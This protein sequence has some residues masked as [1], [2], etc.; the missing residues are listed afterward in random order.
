MRTRQKGSMLLALLAAGGLGGFGGWLFAA[1][2]MPATGAPQ[3][4]IQGHIQNGRLIRTEEPILPDPGAQRA[5]M[6]AALRDIEKQLVAI[7]RHARM[8]Y[9]LLG[10]QRD[11][12][13][14]EK[15]R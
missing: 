10:S 1:A 8:S 6:I 12:S 9:V 7:E 14:Y 5:E 2:Q 3:G 13:P 4:R 15:N 11:A